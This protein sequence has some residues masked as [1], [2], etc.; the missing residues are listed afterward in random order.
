MEKVIVSFDL[1]GTL[2]TH[3]FTRG[4]WGEGV[5]RLLAEKKRISLD[6]ASQFCTDAYHTEGDASIHWYQLDYWL[7]FFGLHEADANEVI[8]GS[9]DKI[10][11][12]D[13]VRST[14]DRLKEK[15]FSLII[16]SNATRLFLDIEV[17]V[18]KIGPYFDEIISLPDDWGMLKS[19]SRAFARLK[20]KKGELVHAGD[21]IC[22][23]YE[24]PRSIG[25]D[26]FH[27]WRGAGPR[28][29]DSLLSLDDLVDRMVCA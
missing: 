20:E 4:V 16:F 3:D 13:D 6:E 5:P 15:N 8:L 7:D 25:I 28:N 10:R 2:T 22:Y 29:A 14:L 19:D 23:D 24:V 26:A 18:L 17:S 12:F 1:D 27:V 21:H 9:A 11:L